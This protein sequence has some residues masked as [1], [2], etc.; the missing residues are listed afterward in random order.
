VVDTRTGVAYGWG[1]EDMD[2]T[3]EQLKFGILTRWALLHPG[4]ASDP[5]VLLYDCS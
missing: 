5:W 2:R 1:I 4:W 3:Q